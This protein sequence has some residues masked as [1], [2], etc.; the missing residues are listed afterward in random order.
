ME[1]N[2]K[3][4]IK[5]GS[6]KARINIKLNFLLLVFLLINITLN[7]LYAQNCNNNVSTDFDNPTNDNL[8][9]LSSPLNPN[10]YLND[11]DWLAPVGG[12]YNEYPTDNMLNLTGQ[13]MVNAFGASAG[14][15]YSYIYDP[16]VY[17]P[18][19]TQNGWELI[20]ANLGYFPNGVPL[21]QQNTKLSNSSIDGGNNVISLSTAAYASGYYFI[22][23][24][25]GSISQTEKLI[26]QK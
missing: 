7:N 13:T 12:I 9:N 26:I 19:V 11:F 4:H 25:S 2:C 14:S 5:S 8:P 10:Y 17:L 20:S 3:S 6:L 21:A 22:N 1:E 18:P 23:V 16:A 24:K 15:Y